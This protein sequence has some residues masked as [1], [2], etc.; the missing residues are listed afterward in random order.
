[1]KLTW[2]VQS[3][4]DSEIAKSAQQT[5]AGKFSSTVPV[6]DFWCSPPMI[7]L[8]IV[9][10]GAPRRSKNNQEKSKAQGGFDV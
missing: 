4:V 2:P 7:L 6:G 8:V 3:E 5:R 9:Q 1:M 10:D